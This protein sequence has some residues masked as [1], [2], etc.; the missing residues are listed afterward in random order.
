MSK[1]YTY[2]SRAVEP[3]LLILLYVLIY[4]YRHVR[5]GPYAE[6]YGVVFEACMIW[7]RH[8]SVSV[9]KKSPEGLFPNAISLY[10]SPSTRASFSVILA[11]RFR[12]S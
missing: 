8:N 7:N 4:L 6:D 2:R 1:D 3:L 9:K 11:I 10:S 12:I 5:F